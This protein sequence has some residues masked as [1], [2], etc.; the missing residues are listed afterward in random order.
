MRPSVPS[1]LRR[2]V[3]RSATSSRIAFNV[4]RPATSSTSSSFLLHRRPYSTP[5]SSSSSSTSSPPRACW[6]C[7]Q[8]CPPTTPLCSSCSA[9]QPVLPTSEGGPNLFQLLGLPEKGSFAIDEGALKLAFLRGSK[10]VH[11]DGFKGKGEIEYQLAQHQASILNKAYYTLKDPLPRAQYLLS[12]SNVEVQESDSITD[13]SLLM[14]I[15]EAREALDDAESEEEV[16]SL[17]E[18]HREKAKQAVKQLGLA[19]EKGDLQ[20]A[21]DLCTELRYWD[22]AGE[23]GKDK[24]HPVD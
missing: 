12:L 13:Q 9:I 17:R 4:A 6:S 21:K 16:E 23:A 3:P 20:R 11:P 24:V 14:E 15:M 8:P 1:L 18:E 19:F 2:S 5:S 22:K 10:D 7:H